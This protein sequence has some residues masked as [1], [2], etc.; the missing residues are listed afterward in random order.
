MAEPGAY[1]GSPVL[2]LLGEKDDNLRGIGL[3]F[4]ARPSMA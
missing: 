1:T 2:M 3:G 4:P